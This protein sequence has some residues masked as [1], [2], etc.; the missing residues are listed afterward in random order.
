MGTRPL[1]TVVAAGMGRGENLLIG[2]C[3][4]CV[5]KKAP[6]SIYIDFYNQCVEGRRDWGRG[7]A[8]AK[9]KNCCFPKV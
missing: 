3:L 2:M 9:E 7:Y 6:S 1:A 8:E 4:R 5:P